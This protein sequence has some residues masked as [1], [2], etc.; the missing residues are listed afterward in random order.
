[1]AHEYHEQLR[2]VAV[3]R[4]ELARPR[5]D[6][7][8]FRCGIPL[9]HDEHAR[10]GDLQEELALGLLQ[11]VLPLRDPELQAAALEALAGEELIYARGLAPEAT[12]LFNHALLHRGPL[13][14]VPG[15]AK[16]IEPRP[17]RILE[18]GRNLPHRG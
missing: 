8:R 15:R 4:S 11:A 18:R 9:G 7:G 3:P 2:R 13:R 17:E 6:L 12:Y 16:L 10:D 5:G 1:M 14:H